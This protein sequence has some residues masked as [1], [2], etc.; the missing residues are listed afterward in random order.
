MGRDAWSGGRWLILS[1][2]EYYEFAGYTSTMFNWEEG[3]K[4]LARL[5]QLEMQVEEPLPPTPQP[6]PEPATSPEP[7]AVNSQSETQASIEEDRMSVIDEISINESADTSGEC[8]KRRRSS[9]RPSISGFCS[10]KVVKVLEHRR[11]AKSELKFK[12][13]LQGIEEVGSIWLT[14]NEVMLHHQE[15]LQ[16][17]LRGLKETNIKK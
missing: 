8:K 3:D 12:V 9:K 16:Q 17:Y 15:G 10:E 4:V 7:E 11:R 1:E 5:E 2:R 14:A 13:L 6:T